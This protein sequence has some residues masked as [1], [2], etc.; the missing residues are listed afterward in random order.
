M[1]ACE[2]SGYGFAVCAQ[3]TYRF[4]PESS[5]PASKDADTT[6]SPASAASMSLHDPALPSVDVATHTRV[7]PTTF[8]SGVPNTDAPQPPSCEVRVP[9]TAY[10]RPV[11]WFTSSADGAPESEHWRSRYACDPGGA[12]GT[13]GEKSAPPSVDVDTNISCCAAPDARLWKSR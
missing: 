2:K 13:G 3:A 8:A 4:P 6:L 1:L 9:N 5:A 10:R 7:S 12:I 11:R